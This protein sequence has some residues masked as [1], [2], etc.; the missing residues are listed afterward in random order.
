MSST[1]LPRAAAGT[2]WFGGGRAGF[3]LRADRREKT[4][5][6]RWRPQG[7][8]NGLA[9]RPALPPGG[10]GPGP[11]TEPGPGSA[12]R[13]T[14]RRSARCARRGRPAAARPADTRPVRSAW[15][16]DGPAA[17]SGSGGAVTPR[18]AAAGRAGGTATAGEVGVFPGE[19]TAHNPLCQ[20][21]RWRFVLQTNGRKSKQ[22][23]FKCSA[24]L[25]SNFN[26]GSR[27]PEEVMKV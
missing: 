7:P 17:K 21:H 8:P 13:R 26:R 10:T 3:V 23:E 16:R 1:A 27:R 24:K 25:W 5:Q 22:P 15:P 20:H 6:G 2:T 19:S 14:R 12:R 18:G 11:G 4:H 9:D